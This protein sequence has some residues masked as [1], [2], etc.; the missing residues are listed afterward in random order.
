MLCHGSLIALR[1]ANLRD[2]LFSFFIWHMKS[3]SHTE[4]LTAVKKRFLHSQLQSTLK[5]SKI[6]TI[7]ILQ[8]FQ[9]IEK[10]YFFN[11]A[12]PLHNL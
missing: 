9:A 10:Q 7:P 3:L 1:S 12:R 6:L 11:L 2:H 8:K 4:T 5:E